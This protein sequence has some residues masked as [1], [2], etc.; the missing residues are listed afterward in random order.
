MGLVALAPGA[1]LGAVARN[2]ALERPRVRTLLRNQ[3]HPTALVTE[4]EDACTWNVHAGRMRLAGK[5]LHVSEAQRASMV[6]WLC[7]ARISAC[8]RT[9]LCAAVNARWGWKGSEVGFGGMCR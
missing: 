9:A 6:S 4:V 5:K 1:A 2:D 3:V 8:L 7:R